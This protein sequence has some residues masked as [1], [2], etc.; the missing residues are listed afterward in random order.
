MF[1]IISTVPNSHDTAKQLLSSANTL[2][3]PQAMEITVALMSRCV[4]INALFNP[5]G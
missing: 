1:Y 2:H 4:K 3:K 5:K